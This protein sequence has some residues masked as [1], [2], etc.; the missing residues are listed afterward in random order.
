MKS[1]II[2]NNGFGSGGLCIRRKCYVCKKH[3]I[4]RGGNVRMIFTQLGKTQLF[5]CSDC[6]VELGV[7]NG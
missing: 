5:T 1:R 4:Q 2:G 3:K 6:L 7:D